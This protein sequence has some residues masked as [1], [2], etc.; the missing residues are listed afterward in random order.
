MTTIEKAVGLEV[1]EI[2][3]ALLKPYLHDDLGFTIV[4]SAVSEKINLH[5]F[6]KANLTPDPK[7]IIFSLMRAFWPSELLAIDSPQTYFRLLASNINIMYVSEQSVIT[8]TNK[9][10]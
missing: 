8:N 10:I 4:H 2:M 6:P 7:K 5:V 3:T 1:M 9:H